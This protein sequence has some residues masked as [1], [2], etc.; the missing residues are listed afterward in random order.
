MALN[1]LIVVFWDVTLCT[2]VNRYLYFRESVAYVYTK[3]IRAGSSE[4]LVPVYHIA[5]YIALHPRR[6]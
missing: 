3:D 4:T 6:L 2:L 1:M 5:N